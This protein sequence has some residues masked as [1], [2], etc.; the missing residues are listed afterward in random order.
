MQIEYLHCSKLTDEYYD[1]S[2]I[3]VLFIWIQT[4]IGSTIIIFYHFK[5]IC[6]VIFNFMQK[7]LFSN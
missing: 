5:I 6:Q 4:D 7:I 2:N 3:I 1:N